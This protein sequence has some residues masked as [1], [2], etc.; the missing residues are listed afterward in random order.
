MS[1]KTIF[2]Y[3][4]T[5]I[6][7]GSLSPHLWAVGVN[8]P[9]D[10]TRDVLSETVPSAFPLDGLTSEDFQTDWEG[11]APPGARIEIESSSLQW[12]RVLDVLVLPRGRMRL[13]FAKPINV[14]INHGGYSTGGTKMETLDFPVA[15]L[16][17]SKNEIRVR[18]EIDGLS[19]EALIRLKYRPKEPSARVRI[20][21]DTSCSRFA[22]QAQL[23]PLPKDKYSW[24]YIGCRFISTRGDQFR[25]SNLEMYVF[26][27]GIGSNDD[28]KADG[29]KTESLRPS[30]WA[31]RLSSKP[32]RL[33]LQG[34][35]GEGL[36]VK[37]NLMDRH[38]LGSLGVGIGPYFSEF[39]GVGE[40]DEGWSPLLTI[41]G[42]LFINES[43]RVVSFDATSISNRL[44]TDFGLYLSTENAKM[45]DQ[46]MTMNLLF[47][48][49]IMGFRTAGKTHAV[50]SFPQGFEFIYL[51][52]FA[53]GYSMSFGGFI[54]PEINGRS[55]YN[56]WWRWGGRIFGEINYLAAKESFGEESV[57]SKSLGVTFGFPIARFW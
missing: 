4:C 54:Y 13:T 26:W 25:T 45:F 6:G 55:Y 39:N 1:L 34:S 24:V 46:R 44:W 53:K 20:Y 49:H 30:L 36:T 5:F 8:I 29:V 21:Q 15:L 42:S 51:D 43:L 32:G 22:V 50:P 2:I 18:Y 52:A 19:K 41:Y 40:Y 17:H 23:E 3:A 31:F 38:Y 56:L 27:E 14:R 9:T 48:G 11:E 37:Y 10:L 35:E 12:V 47:G 7:V 16:T 33:N 57:S 28:L